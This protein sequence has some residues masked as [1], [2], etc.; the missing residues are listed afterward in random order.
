MVIG[1]GGNWGTVWGGRRVRVIRGTRGASKSV[2][3]G[4]A[5]LPGVIGFA[6]MRL[7]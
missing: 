5:S 1:L 4:E 6:S 3:W 7:R 2:V